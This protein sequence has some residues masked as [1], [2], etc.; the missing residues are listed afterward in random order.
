[1]R[2]VKIKEKCFPLPSY[3]LSDPNRVKVSLYGKILDK[4][5]NQPIKKFKS[6]E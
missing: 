4:N 2:N 5:Y 6:M 1:M 3:D